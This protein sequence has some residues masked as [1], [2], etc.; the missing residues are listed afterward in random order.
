MAVVGSA[1]VRVRGIQNGDL[2]GV[3]GHD[4]VSLGEVSRALV[5]RTLEGRG[6]GNVVRGGLVTGGAV[7]AAS[8]G[9]LVVV[10]DGGG[11]SA[12]AAG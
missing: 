1:G 6:R 2:L 8:S 10:R 12:E 7:G 4:G 3:S 5:G 9:I 11:L